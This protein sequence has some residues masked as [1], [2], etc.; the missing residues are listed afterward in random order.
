MNH[1]N[2]IRT[3]VRVKEAVLMRRGNFKRI[4]DYRYSS[5]LVYQLR[6]L[7]IFYEKQISRDLESQR[8][9]L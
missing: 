6:V 5:S 8:F 3:P 7:M 9:D 4:P 2:V 1:L